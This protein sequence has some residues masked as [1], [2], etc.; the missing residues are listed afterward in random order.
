MPDADDD[1]QK[2]ETENRNWNRIHGVLSMMIRLKC[3]WKASA[4]FELE[5]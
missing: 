2:T 3:E 5:L 4:S 1:K